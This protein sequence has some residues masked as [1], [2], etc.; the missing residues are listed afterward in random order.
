MKFEKIEVFNFEGAFRG[1]RNPLDSWQKSDSYTI[2][3]TS[4]FVLGKNDLKLA[5]SLIKAGSEHRKF[6]RQIF[7]SMDITAPRYWWC[8]FDT[9]KVGTVANSCSTMHKLKDYPFTIDMFEL[10][11]ETYNQ[12]Y[13]N[14]VI[15]HLEGLRLNYNSTKDIRWLRA[16]KQALPESFIQKR[17]VTMNYENLYSMNR[18]RDTHRLFEWSTDFINTIKT[19]PYAKELIIC[20]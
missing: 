17:T 18:Q 1:M 9:Y 19:L 2:W 8:E 15:Q 11:G 16:L 6:M 10:D 12:A 20:E 14:I 3:G 7:V 13:W 4:K 5:Q